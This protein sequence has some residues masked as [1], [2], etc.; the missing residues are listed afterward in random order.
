MPLRRLAR[1]LLVVFTFAVPWELAL[2][3]GEPWGPV[4]R[5][6]GI[7]LL[8]AAIP[9]VLRA[10]AIRAPGALQWLTLALFLWFSCSLFWTIDQ[11]ATVEKLRAYFQEMML[12]WLVWEFADTPRDLRQ[13]L[14][15]YVAGSWVLASITLASF[16]SPEAIA[17]G[18]VRFFAEGLDP[19][20][21]ARFLDLAFPMAALLVDGEPRWWGKLLTLGYFPLGMLAVVLTASRGG[22]IA[23]LLA[24]GGSALVMGRAHPR[25]WLAGAVALPALVI[26]LWQIVPAETIDRI[27]T[28]SEQVEGGNF[29]ERANIWA[30]GWQAFLH[31]PLAGSGA[32]SFVSAARLA[33]IDTAHNTA[34]SIAVGGGLCAL[35]LAFAVVVAALRA[36]VRLRG[37]LLPAMGTAMLVWMVTTLTAS[38]EENRSTWILL[39]LIAAAGR[40]AVEDPSALAACF[41]SRRTEHGSRELVL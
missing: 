8:L 13:V 32:G 18:Q 6:A 41:P 12:I 5:V 38:V 9:A 11:A 30:Q 35:G 24:L 14:R 16:A 4:A 15:A 29:N 40:L 3:L 10:K 34:L 7:V 31:A 1:F 37:P 33:P 36:V 26:A 27:A 28:I 2:D 25:R 39:G 20:D 21:T 22:F 23:A 19:N 17:S